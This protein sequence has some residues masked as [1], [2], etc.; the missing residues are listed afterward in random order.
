MFESRMPK[1]TLLLIAVL[2]IALAGCGGEEETPSGPTLTCDPTNSDPAVRCPCMANIVCDQ[3][4]ACLSGTQIQ[5]ASNSMWTYPQ[6]TCVESLRS[7][8]EED[9]DPSYQP[10]DYAACLRDLEA[11][12]CADFGDFSVVSRDFP[13]S[14]ERL[15]ALDTGLEI[16]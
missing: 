16:S 6:T 13:A 7:D 8:C 10:T 14:C 11:A 12:T 1:A 5:A 9:S 2:V 3:M 15:R 4:Y